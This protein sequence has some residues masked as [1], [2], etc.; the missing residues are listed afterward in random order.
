MQG[1]GR[2]LAVYIIAVILSLGFAFALNPFPAG[3]EP[4]Y[5]LDGMSIARDHDL[6]VGDEYGSPETISDVYV[7]DTIDSKTH[8]REF[9]PGGP[10][11]SL[12][13]PLLPAI[14]AP[15]LAT[16]AR[17]LGVRVVLGLLT[18]LSIPVLLSVLDVLG[19]RR[20]RHVSLAILGSAC[21]P[22][23]CY[24]TQIFPD[25]LAGLFVLVGIRACVGGPHHRRWLVGG[26][27][28][29]M[30][31][32]WLQARYLPLSLGIT[33]ALLLIETRPWDRRGTTAW[34]GILMPTIRAAL[35]V[36]GPVLTSL[37]TLLAFNSHI[38]GQASFFAAYQNF[39][40]PNS[41]FSPRN[42][43]LYSFG[44]LFSRHYGVLVIA[45]LL[46]VGLVGVGAALRRWPTPMLGAIGVAAAYYLPTTMIGLWGGYC[47]P[48]RY[49]VPLVLP[50]MIPAA[51]LLSR[52]I[53]RLVAVILAG[54]SLAVAFATALGPLG[55]LYPDETPQWRLPVATSYA[56][57]FPTA[58]RPQFPDR[59]TVTP[60]Q[61][62]GRVGRLA[63][64]HGVRARSV[65][66]E[67]GAGGHLTFGPYLDLRPGSYVAHFDIEV[68]KGGLRLDVAATRG[69]TLGATDVRPMRRQV[70]SVP[71]SLRS[72][73]RGVETRAYVMTPSEAALFGVT[74]G[75]TGP[76]HVRR[77]FP[78]WLGPTLWPLGL[79]VLA[80]GAARRRPSTSQTP[81]AEVRI[82]SRPADE[83][84]HVRTS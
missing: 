33:A 11:R 50:L 82:T 81:P 19:G 64:V 17:W 30:A 18:S 40:A 10:L 26:V 42:F 63:D 71:F 52:P 49:T 44:D 6:D 35:P 37:V 21:L 51:V 74:I 13:S 31:L 57:L 78:S 38:Y 9:I 56:R 28:T 24:A 70:V 46:L 66:P 68:D 2:Y 29:A 4:H 23:I 15:V 3:D 83:L 58:L 77:A 27:L 72:A 47:P 69:R 84:H 61:L 75:Q 59:A 39:D 80:A 5:L 53:W 14:T 55:S 7:R 25:A 41:E 62:F 12:H 20:R 54:V 22:F 1:R 36:G 48:G 76:S 43:F 79:A 73:D 34:G 16:G 65:R 8:A 32:P 67:D 60:D 45:P